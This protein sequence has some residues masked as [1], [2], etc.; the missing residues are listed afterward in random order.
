[1]NRKAIIISFSLLFLFALGLR[2]HHLDHESLFMDELRQISYYPLSLSRIALHAA[3]QTQTPLDY[4]IG[5]FVSFISYSDFAVRLPAALFGTGAVLVLAFLVSELCSWPVGFGTGVIAALLPFNI[6]YSQE[7][8]PY[9]IAI[10]FFLIVLLS[11]HRL[12]SVSDRVAV[13]A[14]VLLLML[15]AFLLSR[16]LSPFVVTMVLGFILFVW[17]AVRAAKQKWSIKS[18][19]HRFALALGAV[20]AAIVIYL[21][22]FNFILSKNARY[23]DI[24]W[25]FGIDAVAAAFEKFNIFP[26]W[27]AFVAQTEPV[28]ALLLILVLLSPFLAGHL[29][30]WTK[31][32]LWTIGILLLPGAA[33]LHLF[34]FKAKSG[35]P[36][37]PPYAIYLLP[38]VLMSA[39]V[40]FQ[41]LLD[42]TGKRAAPLS[43]ILLLMLAG[44]LIVSA[45]SASMAFKGL[46]KKTD[47]RGA[48]T[49][50]AASCGPEQV[51]IFDCL[52]PYGVWEPTFYG[53]WRY[54]RGKSPLVPMER[55]PLLSWKMTALPHEPVVVIFKWREYKL[56]PASHYPIMP[57]PAEL[58]KNIDYKKIAMDP[59]LDV[60]E[61]TG[62]SIIRLKNKTQNLAQDTYSIVSRLLRHLPENSSLVELYLAGGGLAHA[63]GLGQWENHLA[64]ARAL[65]GKAHRNKVNSITSRIPRLAP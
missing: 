18:D 23:A 44:G 63:L 49:H 61:F 53:F 21:P 42:L 55:V 11:V 4:W 58:S 56:T 13:N 60:T 48:C 45:A 62:F 37:R 27:R 47:W 65:A 46:R 2:L 17:L 24:S 34:I 28:S 57:L 36:F 5:H 10:F 32:P 6:Y 7:A 14:A 38:L 1:M 50:L 35:L 8:R 54:Y 16:T 43:R 52:S 31:S 51:L 33:L 41:G 29:R 59:L 15:Y 12:L 64:R 26:I 25:Q 19:D 3:S 40:T 22:M 20:V 39:A 30:L 9:S